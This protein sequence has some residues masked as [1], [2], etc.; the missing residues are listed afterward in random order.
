MSRRV[1]TSTPGGRTLRSVTERLHPRHLLAALAV[2]GLGLALLVGAAGGAGA[3]DNGDYTSKPPA[4]T[5]P[6]LAAPAQAVAPPAAP[7]SV[8]FLAITGSDLPGIAIFGTVLVAAGA[9]L[10]VLRRRAA[11]PDA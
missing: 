1:L 7:A 5:A 3:Q 4:V 2:L 10:L 6:P 8:R 11:T 9:G